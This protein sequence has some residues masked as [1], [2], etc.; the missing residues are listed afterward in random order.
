MSTKTKS[1]KVTA[2]E[3][4]FFK[5]NWPVG[6]PSLIAESLERDGLTVTRNKVHRELTTIKDEYDPVIIQR[7]HEVIKLIKGVEFN[8][9]E[10]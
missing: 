3:L 6:L 10:K 4:L 2:R 7:A 5:D 1:I 8:P 9:Q